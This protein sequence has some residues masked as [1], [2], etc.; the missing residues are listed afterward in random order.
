MTF[1]RAVGIPPIWDGSVGRAGLACDEREQPTKEPGMT[2]LHIEHPIT[3][4]DVW[5]AAFDRFAEARATA[6]VRAQRVLHP[7][8]DP[9]YILVDLDFTTTEEAQRFLAFLEDMV[10]SSTDNAPALAGTPQT[11]LLQAAR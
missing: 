9:N 6:G 7:V 8:D 1:C 5:L 3:D 2:T 10:W 4:L 11:K